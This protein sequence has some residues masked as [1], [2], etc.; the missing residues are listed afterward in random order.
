MFSGVCV[1]GSGDALLFGNRGVFHMPESLCAD[2]LQ[3]N[4]HP[5]VIP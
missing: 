2:Q 4:E 1:D 3:Y 5:G